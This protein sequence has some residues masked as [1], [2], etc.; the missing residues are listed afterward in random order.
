CSSDL[1]DP[2]FVRHSHGLTPTARA[3]FLKPKLDLLINQLE[4]LTLPEEFHPESSEYRFRIAAVESVYPLILPHF[5]PSIFQQ[6]PNVTIS[7]HSWSE[8][9][10][11]MLQR[12]ELDLGMTGK[13]IDI[14]DAK[15][16]MLPPF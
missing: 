4:H 14:N 10:F 11:K 9:T 1:D 3:L 13:D 7:T 16:T 12:G 2:L 15:L 8:Q 6:A 5:L